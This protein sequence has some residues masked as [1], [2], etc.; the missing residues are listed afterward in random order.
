MAHDAIELHIA[1]KCRV[2]NQCPTSKGK[3]L[4]M[5]Q[6]RISI[7]WLLALV[8]VVTSA[9]SDRREQRASDPLTK[10]NEVAAGESRWKIVAREMNWVGISDVKTF[11]EDNTVST[12]LPPISNRHVLVIA[13]TAV[14]AVVSTNFAVETQ[15]RLSGWN[16]VRLITLG[17]HL[18]N[19]NVM[20]QGRKSH[21]EQNRWLNLHVTTANRLRLAADNPN[22]PLPTGASNRVDFVRVYVVGAPGTESRLDVLDVPLEITEPEPSEMLAGIEEILDRDIGKTSS[23]IANYFERKKPIGWIK[24]E[25]AGESSERGIALLEDN[26]YT[27]AVH[28]SFVFPENP[29]WCEDPFNDA[30]WRLRLQGFD[31]LHQ[32]TAA[33]VSSGS[34]EYFKRAI[35]LIEDW[36]SDMPGR[37]PRDVM[38]WNDHSVPLRLERLLN[39]FEVHRSPA[40]APDS[41]AFLLRLIHA[42][43]Q[44]CSDEDFYA[45]NQPTRV[46]NHAFFQDR[47]L[48]RAALCFPE[49]IHAEEWERTAARRIVFQMNEGLTSDGVWKENT[50]GYH[51]GMFK[52]VQKLNALWKYHGRPEVLKKVEQD[53]LRFILALAEVDGALVAFGD[54]PRHLMRAEVETEQLDA[55]YIFS[56]GKVGHAPEWIDQAFL[57]SG[58]VAMRDRWWPEDRFYMGAHTLMLAG[59]NSVTHKHRDDLSFLISAQGER[60]LVDPGFYSSDRDDP[61]Q[62]YAWSARGHNTV[63]VDDQDFPVERS[64]IGSTAV[65]KYKSEESFAYVEATT[66]VYRNID[67]YRKLVYLR[68]NV[69]FVQDVLKSLDGMN[70]KF[71]QNFHF[72]PDKEVAVTKGVLSITADSGSDMRI[73]NLDGLGEPTLHRGEKEPQV[74]GWFFPVYGQAVPCVC[75]TYVHTGEEALFSKLIVLSGED[76]LARKF[77]VA[78][79]GEIMGMLKSELPAEILGRLDMTFGPPNSRQQ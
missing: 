41:T 67:F 42:H 57:D 17:I 12:V 19:G 63:S 48:L 29:T 77:K 2:T 64:R 9:C 25:F 65:T 46:H 3:R 66:K 52:H 20:Y 60:W 24:D 40:M 30:N 4:K 22:R 10:E 7:V 70:H 33:S 59:F 34:D 53:M 35:Y 32:L 51:L 31:W 69:W 54:N 49:F 23:E 73:F 15:V 6:D 79:T 61:L 38:V 58:Y 26:E 76:P 28:P 36:T 45:R 37:M 75:A 5:L 44:F 71:T 47:A 39:F 50:S 62:I 78:P 43:A 68:P 8:L 21:P 27:T 72:S 18:D 56:Q 14:S 13:D 55:K 16:S 11:Q 1:L 74:L